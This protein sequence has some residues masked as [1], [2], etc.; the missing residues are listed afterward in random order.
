VSPVLVV[1]VDLGVAVIVVEEAVVFVIFVVL[2]EVV[3]VVVVVDVGVVVDVVEVSFVL[4]ILGD[5]TP[6]ILFQLKD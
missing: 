6:S 2:G 4:V 5:S 1:L 3:A